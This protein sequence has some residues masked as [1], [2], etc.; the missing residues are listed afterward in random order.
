MNL[1]TDLPDASEAELF[2]EILARQAEKL[3]LR[4]GRAPLSP[5]ACAPR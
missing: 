1:V 4:Y 2:E 5:S 3:K